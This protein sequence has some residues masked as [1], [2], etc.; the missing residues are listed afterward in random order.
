MALGVVKER[1]ERMTVEGLLR[2]TL[3]ACLMN[4]SRLLLSNNNYF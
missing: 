3:Y 2:R 1:D 4:D